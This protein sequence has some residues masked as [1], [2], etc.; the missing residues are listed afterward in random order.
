[1]GDGIPRS[2]QSLKIRFGSIQNDGERGTWRCPVALQKFGLEHPPAPAED[3]GG[4]GG[5]PVLLWGFAG[6]PHS[7][8]CWRSRVGSCWVTPKH[9]GLSLLR[10]MGAL[11]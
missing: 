7:H 10:L 2:L 8:V 1:M 6:H 9:W 5:C 11:P 3:L 4:F